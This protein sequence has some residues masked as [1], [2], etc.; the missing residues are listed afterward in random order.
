MK[1]AELDLQLAKIAAIIEK[2]A[3][4]DIFVGSTGKSPPPRRRSTVRPRSWRIVCAAPSPI[5]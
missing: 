1:A 5:R 4:P 3:D 2:M